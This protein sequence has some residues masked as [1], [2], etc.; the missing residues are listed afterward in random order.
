MLVTEFTMSRA[1]GLTDAA[2]LMRGRRG[3][4][5]AVE[6]VRRWAN[7]ARGCYPSGQSGPQLVLRTHR[8]NG[9][10]LTLREWVE[11]FERARAALGARPVVVKLE[12]ERK[13][14]KR[15]RAHDRAEAA[16]DRQGVPRG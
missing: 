13:G 6:T 3:K 4:N 15:Q 5:P 16:L 7:P 9:E 10:L 12:T 2:R 1:I 14:P 8:V 11:E